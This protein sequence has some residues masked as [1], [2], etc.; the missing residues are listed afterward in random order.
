MNAPFARR[1][2]PCP[3]GS[4]ARYKD[5]HGKLSAPVPAP[6]L[7]VDEAFQRG[8]QAHRRSEPQAAI[9]FF[10]AVLAADPGHVFA[11]HFKGYDLCQLGRFDEGMPLLERALAAQPRNADFQGNTG[12]IHYVLGDLPRAVKTLERAIALAPGMAEPYSNLAM[13]LR[14][15]GEPERALVAVRHALER[16]PDLPGARLNLALVLLALGRFDEAWPAYVWRPQPAV[17]LRDFGIAA[18]LPH[19]ARL[20]AFDADPWITLHGEQGLGDVIFFMRYAAALRG[21]GVRIRFWGDA[22]VAPMLLR[23][24]V[25]DEA[26]PGAAPGPLDPARL[27]WIGDLP[28]LLGMQADF[29]P[30]VRLVADAARVAALRERLAAIGPAP[31]I[32]LTWRA[33]LPRRG[34][35]VLAKAIDPGTLGAALNGIE[36]TFVSLQRDPAPGEREALEAALGA[37]VADFSSSNAD[38]DESL[39]LLDAVGEYVGVS[40]TNT[41]LAAS[42]GLRA[43]VLVPWPAEWRWLR[44]GDA[45]PWFPGL[46]LYRA[47]ARGEWGPALDGLAAGLRADS[48]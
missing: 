9:P 33:G 42:L 16:N 6:A 27:V 43:R 1:N 8:M 3:C 41:H 5:C 46:P 4:G 44:D 7:G 12:I 21:R 14:D 26:F 19:A 29:P 18:T 25:I 36:A 35:A 10:D 22:R 2:D 24:S 37:K 45:S 17:N 34:K 30:P 23:S 20:P 11:L 47:T 15:A 31:Y 13:A 39:A 48:R 40:N 32:A 38:L 28:A